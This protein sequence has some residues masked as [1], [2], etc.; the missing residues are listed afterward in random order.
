MKIGNAAHEHVAQQIGHPVERKQRRN[1]ARRDA[2]FVNQD[3]RAIAK[4]GEGAP[5]MRPLVR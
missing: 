5:M 4:R 2:D 3:R 1:L